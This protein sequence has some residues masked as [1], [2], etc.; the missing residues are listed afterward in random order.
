LLLPKPRQAQVIPDLEGKMD[1]GTKASWKHMIASE[2]EPL[3]QTPSSDE[4]SQEL[5]EIREQLTK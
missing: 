3:D 5:L 1:D 4:R 2:F